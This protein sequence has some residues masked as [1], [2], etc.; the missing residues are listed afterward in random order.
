MDSGNHLAPRNFFTLLT[1]CSY[2][3]DSLLLLVQSIIATNAAN[4]FHPGYP[5]GLTIA[6]YVGMLVGALFWGLSAD[7]IGRRFAFNFSLLISSIFAIVC[8]A[9]P[10]WIVLGLFVSLSAFGSGGNL[11][12]DTAVFLEF[13]PSQKQ[14]LLTLMAAWWG[15]GQLIAG[16]FAWAFLPNYS[17]AS[18]DGC[19]KADNWGWRY[20]W[21]AN[22]ALVL[23]MS[24]MRLTVIRLKETP[25]YLVSEGWDED[26]VNVLQYIATKYHRSCSLTLEK[27]QA[28]DALA[29]TEMRHSSSPHTKSRL[30]FGEVGGHLR[31]LFETRRIGLSTSLIWL[32]WTLIGLAYPLYNVF[33]PT[34]LQTRGAQTGD[35]SQFITWRNYAIVNF[36]GILGPIPAGLMCASGW[37][38]G[39]RGTMIIGALITMVFFFAYTQVRTASENLGFNCAI[40]FS[41]NIYYGWYVGLNSFMF[42]AEAYSLIVSMHIR[43]KCYPVRIVELETALPLDSIVSWAFSP[44]SSLLLPTQAPQCQST[45]VPRC[46]LSWPLLLPSFP[47]SLMAHEV[48]ELHAE[49]P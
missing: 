49:A 32:S 10:N 1:I 16:L 15:V 3:T 41:L 29:P 34:Y 43:Q 13:L 35:G 14:W 27:M 37:F 28:C 47:L 20:V 38:W 12:L 5:K 44:P 30:S 26:V 48:H 8:G 40:N 4:E 7:I 33:L 46:T 25:K 22:G 19:T 18:A 6:V 39:R 24:I 17:C 45:F 11:V 21:F 2:A 31:G 42:G 9:A 23:V 36:C